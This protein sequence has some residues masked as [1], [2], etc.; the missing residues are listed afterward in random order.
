[1]DKITHNIRL[2]KWLKIVQECTSSGLTKREWCL[3]NG[4]D[5]RIYYY[6]Q[7]KVRIEAHTGTKLI[8]PKQPPA[9]A[10]VE[11]SV[12]R[13]EIPVSQPKGENPSD[14][15]IIKDAITIN[16]KNSASPELLQVVLQGLSYAQ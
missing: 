2:A 13:N 14:I 15:I 8:T 11:L 3:Q 6:W 4:I 16:I 5:S 9:K 10:F 7:R 1:M 12:P